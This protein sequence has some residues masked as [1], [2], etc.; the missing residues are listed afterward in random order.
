MSDIEKRIAESLA[1]AFE[2]LPD[3][4]K[5]FVLG[6]A[7][8]AIAVAEKSKSYDKNQERGESNGS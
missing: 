2:V 1:K 8:G 6:Y 5:E 7:E 4:K 3:E